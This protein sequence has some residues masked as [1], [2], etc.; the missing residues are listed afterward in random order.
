M[1]E[2]GRGA[3]KLSERRRGEKSLGGRRNGV[4]GVDLPSELRVMRREERERRTE[5]KRRSVA[6]RVL[7]ERG[8]YSCFR[9][10]DNLLSNVF[11]V[12]GEVE[13]GQETQFVS[14]LFSPFNLSLF[15]RLD[16]FETFRLS[17]TSSK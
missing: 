1:R 9:E 3:D 11:E 5:R 10:L 2:G 13:E 15:F 14:K 12:S 7:G 8:G 17:I 6:R 4:G 16:Q